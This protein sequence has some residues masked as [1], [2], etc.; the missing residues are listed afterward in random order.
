MRRKLK[1]MWTAYSFMLVLAGLSIGAAVHAWMT[2]V[3]A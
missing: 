3:I 2:G 1:S